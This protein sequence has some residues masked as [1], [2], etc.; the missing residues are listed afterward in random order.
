MKTTIKLAFSA[1]LAAGMCWMT[2][3]LF[4]VHYART[5]GFTEDKVNPVVWSTFGMEA[6]LAGLLAWAFYRIVR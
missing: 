1:G 6:L 5:E 3:L 4:L 2:G